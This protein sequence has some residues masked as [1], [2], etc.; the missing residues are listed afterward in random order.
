M[1]F[2]KTFMG[3][4][5]GNAIRVMKVYGRQK[6]PAAQ[7]R[8]AGLVLGRNPFCNGLMKKLLAMLLASLMIKGLH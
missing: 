5:S 7:E 4:Q 8:A 6:E 3:T 1:N 2:S